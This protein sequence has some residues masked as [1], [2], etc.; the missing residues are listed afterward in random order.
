MSKAL[1]RLGISDETTEMLVLIPNA[2][3][4]QIADIR[5]VVAGDE[6][7]N[8]SDG[9]KE[10]ARLAEIRKFYGVTEV[11]EQSGLLLDAIVTRMACREVR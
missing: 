4:K 10:T 11:E 8:V 1:T 6:V 3:G 5:A 7:L 9:V 2:A